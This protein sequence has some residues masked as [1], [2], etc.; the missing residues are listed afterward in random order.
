MSQS[1]QNIEYVI[2]DGGS[3]DETLHILKA[4]PQ[5]K[6][7]SEKEN[8]ETGVFDALRKAIDMSD[9]EYIAWMPFSDLFADKDW[10]KLC[11]DILNRDHQVSW[12]WGVTQAIS[13]D[14]QRKSIISFAECFN[15]EQPR[16]QQPPQK[17]DFLPYWLATGTAME[18][19]A[20][21]RRKVFETCFPRNNPSEPYQFN[22]TLGFNYKLN[23]Q[24]YLPYFLPVISYFGRVHGGQ[25]S[26]KRYA[27]MDSASHK[28]V[29]NIAQYKRELLSGKIR[30]LFRDGSS[31]VIGEVLPAELHALRKR[32]FRYKLKQ[33]LQRRFLRIINR[34]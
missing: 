6:W 15:Q 18:S 24:G 1:Y 21:Y 29:K 3:T 31:Q 5:L 33:K 12:V 8:S 27:L 2:V 14:G 25:M 10:L 11:V 30:H 16:Y 17:T 26:E 22:P 34:I 28:Y 19:N 23:T 4:Y 13:E 32:I 7:V 9:G 20:V